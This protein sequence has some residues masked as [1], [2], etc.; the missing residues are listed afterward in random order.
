[1]TDE[2]HKTISN[3]DEAN[4][5]NGKRA[6]IS[7]RKLASN[8]ANA[9]KSTGPQTQRGKSYSR[10]NS[11]KHGLLAQKVM[12]DGSG[13]LLDPELLAL[14]EALREQYGTD[15]IRVQLLLDTLIIDCWRMKQA[16]ELEVRERSKTYGF[17]A[18]PWMPQVQRY[19]TANR[20]SFMKNLDLLSKA[21]QAD[22]G[23]AEAGE[24]GP[25]PDPRPDETH[26]DKPECAEA[27]PTELLPLIEVPQ[28]SLEPNP[29]DR[30]VN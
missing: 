7:E 21:K 29:A 20:N 15:D 9:L 8:R 22:E 27:T 25:Q 30:H 14:H 10:L 23:D 5:N 12:F 17:L 16:L 4:D 3:T 18:N 26:S 19:A 13:K 28:Q 24:D 6:T 1:M 2:K 11:F